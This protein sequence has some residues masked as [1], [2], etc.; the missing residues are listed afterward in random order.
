MSL[1]KII[2]FWIHHN[3]AIIQWT[4][5][6][7][8]LLVAVMI[9]FLIRKPDSELGSSSGELH[10][11]ESSLK[12][13]LEQAQWVQ[14][15][16][17]VQKKSESSA[18]DEDSLPELDEALKEAEA[19]GQT[20]GTG[21]SP[22]AEASAQ[23]QKELTAKVEEIEQLQRQVAELKTQPPVEGGGGGSGGDPE[24]MKE[25]QGKVEKLEAQ[26]QEYE[27]IEDDIADLS[28]YKDENARLKKELESLKAGG[29]VATEDSAPEE[30]EPTSEAAPKKE[31]LVAEFAQVVESTQPAEKEP[32]AASPPADVSS[33]VEEEKAPSS[34]LDDMVKADEAQKVKQEN[35]DEE[36]F[37]DDI[38]AEFSAAVNEEL[39]GELKEA[40]ERPAE[41]EVLLDSTSES[42]PAVEEPKQ[43]EPPALEVDLDST[44]GAADTESLPASQDEIDKLLQASSED[45]AVQNDTE[46]AEVLEESSIDTDKMLSELSG[47]EDVGEVEA[48]VALN[49]DMDLEKMAAEATGLE[50]KS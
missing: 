45:S 44:S 9:Y 13:L 18:T 24:A 17:H 1:D 39:G 38:L 35:K 46:S 16:P 37:S 4:I 43:T 5:V 3:E 19:D 50:E 10:D 26:L 49:E 14:A 21:G 42:E 28:H 25:L 7:I 47:L 36:F 31:D 15:Q 33:A 34:E 48:D 23:L 8:F 32:E 11:I 20:G 6:T 2:D 22:S 40:E 27:I 12:K 29:A 41:E 30:E